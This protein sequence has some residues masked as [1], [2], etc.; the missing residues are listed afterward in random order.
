MP[1]KILLVDDDLQ[2]LKLVGLMLQRRGYVIMAARG[3]VQ[4][5]AKAESDAPDLI[6]LDVMMPDL[7]GLE[8]CR[9]L[10]S[11]PSTSQIPIIMFTAKSDVGDKVDGFQSG[12]DDYL[13][14]PIHP[15]DLAARVDAALQRSAQKR[16]NVQP[17]TTA[18]VIGL[19]GVRGGVGTT[20][21]ALNLAAAMANADGER[22]VILVDLQTSAANIAAQLGLGTADGLAALV[23]L[24]PSEITPVALGPRLIHHASGM[25]LLVNADQPAPAALLT[26]AQ[27]TALISS[28]SQLAH[29][30]VLDLGSTLDDLTLTALGLCRRVVLALEP[31]RIAVAAAQNVSAQLERRGIPAARLSAALINRTTG[32]VMLD[33]QVIEAQLKLPIEVLL[34]PVPEVAGQAADESNLIIHLQPGGLFAEQIRTLAQHLTA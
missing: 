13:T 20:T 14:K 34:P 29:I 11:Q 3:G 12:A 4:G 9:R 2:S 18:Q 26:A 6:L 23:S 5:L 17:T 24:E 31:Q 7:D 1:A 27:V 8:V 28:V 21:L 25:S 16:L 22:R 15:N 19:L 32:T 33:K 30:V 10:R